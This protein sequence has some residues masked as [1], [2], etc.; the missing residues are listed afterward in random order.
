ML[1]SADVA[2]NSVMFMQAGLLL[3]V[4]IT[5]LSFSLVQTFPVTPSQNP[6]FIYPCRLLPN[7]RLHAQGNTL[8]VT[9]Y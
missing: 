6:E 7:I 2:I 5:C 8:H 9:F 3:D 4:L 1:A